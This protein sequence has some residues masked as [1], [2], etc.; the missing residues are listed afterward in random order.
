MSKKK[1]IKKS[2]PVPDLVK[3]TIKTLVEPYVG[4]PQSPEDK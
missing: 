2:L 4:S 3:H 1:A